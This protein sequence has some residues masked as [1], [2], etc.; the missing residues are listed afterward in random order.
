MLFLQSELITYLLNIIMIFSTFK[1]GA[2][3]WL[4]PGQPHPG[5]DLVPVAL[6][7]HGGGYRMWG[8]NDFERGS[9]GTGRSAGGC[10]VPP[11]S[12]RRVMKQLG[13]AGKIP[14][15]LLAPPPPPHACRRPSAAPKQRTDRFQD[16]EALRDAGSSGTGWRGSGARASAAAQ[17]RAWSVENTVKVRASLMAGWW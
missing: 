16:G 4:G 15:A 1:C 13:T 3:L 7:S 10:P 12:F 6:G 14:A 9:Q 5:K 17:G 11:G 2:P 8:A